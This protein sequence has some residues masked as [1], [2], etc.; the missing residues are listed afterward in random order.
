[1]DN[2]S[3]F[4]ID[5]APVCIPCRINGQGYVLERPTAMAAADWLGE[6]VK[7][8]KVDDEGNVKGIGA[9]ALTLNFVLLAS[10]LY[11]AEL[12]DGGEV[13]ER[14]EL[15]TE[16]EIRMMPNAAV[17]K[18]VEKAKQ[19]GGMETRPS[20]RKLMEQRISLDKLIVEAKRDLEADEDPLAD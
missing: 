10:C 3:L 20:L 13:I 16:D 8:A 12:S 15:A 18:L 6:L 17:S 14:G 7:E 9:K 4:E 5:I 11:H 1:M 19:I 2:Q